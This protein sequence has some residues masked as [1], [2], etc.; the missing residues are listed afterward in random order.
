MDTGQWLGCVRWGYE[1]TGGG[2]IGSKLLPTEVSDTP[3][4]SFLGAVSNYAYA[5][6]PKF[7]NTLLIP[8]PLTWGMPAAFFDPS[9]AYPP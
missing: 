4:A 3:S 2:K 5:R 1:T 6:N 8:D 9:V 7:V